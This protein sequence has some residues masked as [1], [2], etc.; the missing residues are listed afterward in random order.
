[1]RITYESGRDYDDEGEKACN[2]EQVK[3][4]FGAIYGEAAQGG[5][6]SKV[7]LWA[8]QR[9]V[10]RE[11]HSWIGGRIQRTREFSNDMMLG[12]LEKI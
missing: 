4:D 10:G 2:A 1:M 5:W 11:R 3:G 8:M 9:T 7:C 12:G 6:R